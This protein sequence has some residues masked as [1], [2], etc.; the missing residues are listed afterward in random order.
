MDKDY[1]VAEISEISH[2][3]FSILGNET[4]KRISCMS[5]TGVTLPNLVENNQPEA[6]GLIDPLMGASGDIDCKTC[7]YNAKYCNGHPSH[8]ELSEPLIHLG[9]IVPIKKILKSICIGCSKLLISKDSPELASIL[10]TK[11][12]SVR[13]N[14]I[15]KLAEKVKHCSRPNQECGMKRSTIKVEIKKSSTEIRIYSEIE[16][17]DGEKGQYSKKKFEKTLSAKRIADIFDK[18]SPED[19]N[20]LGIDPAKNVPSDMI[21]KYFPIPPMHVRPSVR[22]FFSDGTVKE[23]GLTHKLASIVKTNNK[24]IEDK[25]KESKSKGYNL[26]LLQYY[27]SSIVDQDAISNPKDGNKN[28]KPLADRYKGKPGRVRGNLMGKR[29]NYNARSVIT[30]DPVE[31]PDQVGVPVKVAMHLTFPEQVTPDNIERLEKLVKNGTDVYPGANYVI[32][33]RS[34][35]TGRIRKIYLKAM[36]D[37]V[38]LQYGDI[39]HRHLMND[40]MVILNRQPSLH[41]QSMMA[42]RAKIINKPWLKTFRLSLSVTPPYNADFDGDEM[43]IFVPQSLK[44]NIEINMIANV[45]EQLITPSTSRAC[46]G[47]VQDG[48]LGAFNMTADDVVIGWRDAVNMLGYTTFDDYESIEKRDYTGKEVMSMIIPKGINMH[49]KQIHIE[50]GEIIS[51]QMDKSILGAGK[52]NGLIQIIWSEYGSDAAN[53][54]ISNCQRL[55]NKFNLYRPTTVGPIDAKISDE[56]KD[57]IRQYIKTVE[58]QVNVDIT[59]IENNPDYMDSKAFE[60]KLFTDINVVRDTVSKMVQEMVHHMNNFKNMSTSGSKGGPN[61]AGQMIGCVG[62]QVVGD[63]RVPKAYNGRSSCYFPK[64]D[65][66]A[67]SRGLCAHPYMSGLPYPEYIYHSAA[68]RAGTVTVNVKTAE[69]GYIQR[70]LVKNMESIRVNYDG[71]ASQYNQIIQD[72]YGSN[73]ADTTRQYEYKVKMIEM[74]D[75]ELKA[76]VSL[77]KK[78]SGN[79]KLFKNMKILRDLIRQTSVKS[80]IASVVINDKFMTPINITRITTNYFRKSGKGK[81]DLTPDYVVKRIE[82]LLSNSVTSIVRVHHSKN[83]NKYVV[84]DNAIVKTALAVCI[85]DAIHPK[86]LIEDVKMSKSTFDNMINDLA[87]DYHNNIVEPGEMVGIIS[88][89]SLGEAVTQITLDTFHHSGVASKNKSTSGVPRINELIDIAKNPKTPSM[90]V[91]LTEDIRESREIATRIASYLEHTTIGDVRGKINVIYDPNPSYGKGIME[92][93]GIIKDFYNKKLSNISCKAKLENLPFLMR[94]EMDKEKMLDKQV[95]LL[96]IKAKFCAWWEQKHIR[97]KRKDKKSAVLKKVT[98]M[99]IYSNSDSDITPILHIRFNAKDIDRSDIKKSSESH[100]FDENTIDEFVELMDDF[101]LKGVDGITSVDIRREA[102]SKIGKKGEL[103]KGEEYVLNTAGVNL[104]EIRY[105]NGIDIYR[106][107]SD[108]VR[109]VYETFG[110]VNTRNRLLYEFSTAYSNAGNDVNGQHV[111]LLVDKMCYT[112]APTPISRHGM[113]NA[114]MDPLDKASFEK[115]VEILFHAATYGEIDT[116]EGVSSRIHTGQV[117]K[118]GTG[119]CDILLDIDLIRNSQFVDDPTLEGVQHIETNTIASSVLNN[120]AGEDIFIPGI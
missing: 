4:V 8:I 120:D 41:K 99:A 49:N 116:Q 10:K 61:Q 78:W 26:L 34:L 89:Q 110:I 72:F 93:D 103:I 25:D 57:L 70:K 58:N 18:I 102:Y 24:I 16:A 15:S 35:N 62:P 65:D 37:T 1:N 81:S 55:V 45:K 12:G 17:Q 108:D 32:K 60:G 98:S 63:G 115:T 85:Y 74:D 119:Y 56:N 97:T 13:L 100:M 107:V 6:G 101:K 68:G 95:S 53:N 80:N 48:L 96:D 114:V 27:A 33:G 79:G 75:T 67:A 82:E 94:I 23:D 66:S 118:G 88:A 19:A 20:I 47:L 2:L 112:G 92:N 44:T 31:D 40:D 39:V 52:K 36:K 73:G 117:V 59:M 109:S 76:H 7:G 46:M 91:Y 38:T 113:K 87:E 29:C 5:D 14:R 43:N 77:S 3:E 28:F 90:D 64:D 69:T 104:E 30:A 106:T 54:F 105:I 86:K 22:G 84:S 111:A 83:D 42:H 51:G 11:S 9:Y 71:T 50:D 21:Y